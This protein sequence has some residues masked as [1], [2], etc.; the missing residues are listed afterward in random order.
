MLKIGLDIDQVLADFWNPYIKRFGQPKD[1]S[2]I[3]KHCERVLIKDKEFWTTL[4]VIRVPNFTPTL[5]CTKR[6]N[7]KS[8]I[9]EYLVNNFGWNK[10]PIYQMLYQHGNKARM[11]KGR[12]DVFVDDSVSN[13]IKMNLSGVPCLLMDSPA[14]QSWGPIGRVY[15]LN[16][17]EI[18]D[19]YYLFMKTVF[20]NFKKY[21]QSNRSN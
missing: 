7:P 8:Y 11:I 2:I 9:R 3:T 13:F 10:I 5:V 19:A 17:E 20:N 14:N 4:P 16:Y 21:V 18:E 12:V 6:V 1:D 15:S